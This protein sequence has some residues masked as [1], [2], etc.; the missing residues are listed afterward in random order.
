[1]AVGRSGCL[2]ASAK[3]QVPSAP[4]SRGPP[5]APGPRPR[6]RPPPTRSSKSA[7]VSSRALCRP[8]SPASGGLFAARS[9]I[10]TTASSRASRLLGCFGWL[11]SRPSPPIDS[12][13]VLR[14]WLNRDTQI[15]QS[16][17]RLFQGIAG[18]GCFA[19]G[20]R[21]AVQKALQGARFSATGG[22]SDSPE[23]SSMQL[24]GKE[25]AAADASRPPPGAR[26]TTASSRA[27]D[28]RCPKMTTLARPRTLT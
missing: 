22:S 3:C 19:G 16:L 9:A 10:S 23:A 21:G 8:H 12:D 15:A 6:A 28:A 24:H 4:R 20:P 26:S 7:T 13:R 11:R 27:D 14:C 17:N 18:L 25:E 5:R 2:C 1:M